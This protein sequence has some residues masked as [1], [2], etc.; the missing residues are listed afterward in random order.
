MRRGV[1]CSECSEILVSASRH[2]WHTC[3]CGA[4]FVDG[5]RAYLRYGVLK[6]G[7]EEPEVVDV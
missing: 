6:E 5:G 3:A 4:T 1:K 7:V 2:D